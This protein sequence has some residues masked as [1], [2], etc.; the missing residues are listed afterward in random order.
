MLKLWMWHTVLGTKHML[1]AV[2]PVRENESRGNS[3]RLQMQSPKL[4]DFF[5]N[6]LKISTV[7]LDKHH[8]VF[9]TDQKTVFKFYLKDVTCRASTR[10]IYMWWQHGSATS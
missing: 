3:V 2:A 4:L 1:R 7:Y 10:H 5:L 8:L 9:K 6:K